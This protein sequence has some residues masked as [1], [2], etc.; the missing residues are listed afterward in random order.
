MDKYHHHHYHVP[1]LQK[2]SREQLTSGKNEA[3][4]LIRNLA[5]LPENSIVRCE[6][7]HIVEELQHEI[8]RH[9]ALV[10][11]RGSFVLKLRYPNSNDIVTMIPPTSTLSEFKVLAEHYASF[12]LGRI[13]LP[14]GSFISE[15]DDRQIHSCGIN[16]NDVICLE[17]AF[18]EEEAEGEPSPRETHFKF[19][20]ADASVDIDLDNIEACVFVGLHSFVLDS[21]FICVAVGT[22]SV[23]GFAPPVK[24]RL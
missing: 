15:F 16:H 6:L 1:S 12:G 10:D 14:D 9:T 17:G 24:G 23:P 22:S 20:T 7:L 11:G 4:D 3:S 18:Q 13:V 8:D 21:G 2:Y 19:Q 5:A